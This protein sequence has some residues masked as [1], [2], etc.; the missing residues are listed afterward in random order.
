M[1]LHRYGDFRV[2]VFYFDS[3][4]TLVTVLGQA[5]ASAVKICGLVDSCLE[6]LKFNPSGTWST[7][8]GNIWHSIWLEMP[9]CHGRSPALNMV[10]WTHD[11]EF[12]NKMLPL[13][14]WNSSVQHLRHVLFPV[15]FLHDCSLYCRCTSTC[16]CRSAS[17]TVCVCDC[18]SVCVCLTVC[19]SV[20]CSSLW[21]AS[22]ESSV[23]DSAKSSTKTEDQEMVSQHVT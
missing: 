20:C 1:A 17:V 13:L 16:M 21:Y 10:V 6:Q 9:N 12:I 5:M 11:W 7:R 15:W 18:M 19:V 2:E 3:P 14:T 22:N 4:C 23:P 8:Y